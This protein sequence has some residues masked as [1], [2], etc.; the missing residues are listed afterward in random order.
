MHRLLY[1]TVNV[2]WGCVWRD[3]DRHTVVQLQGRE[4]DQFSTVLNVA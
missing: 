3:R 1:Y 4:R 2:S